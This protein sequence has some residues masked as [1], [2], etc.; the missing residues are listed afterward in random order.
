M[1]HL[2]YLLLPP[3]PSW[4]QAARLDWRSTIHH[5]IHLDQG[6][7]SSTVS[8]YVKPKWPGNMTA[9]YTDEHYIVIW[10]LCMLLLLC[11]LWLLAVIFASP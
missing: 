8:I 11:M 6:V 5:F 3:V 9:T 10:E 7:T 1:W 2:Y 4:L